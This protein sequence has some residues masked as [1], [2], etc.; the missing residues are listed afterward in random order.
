MN[1][2]M[3]RN[4]QGQRGQAMAVLAISAVALLALA[5]LVIDGGN[6]FA[7]QR[8]TQNGADAASE[9]GA[10][11]LMQKLAGVV[12]TKTGSDVDTAVQTTA[13]ANGLITPVQACYTDLDG[14]PLASDGSMAAD[15]SSAAQVGPGLP[16]PP[17]SA[18]PGSFAAGVE[19]H[20]SRSFTGYFGGIVGLPDGLASAKATARAGYVNGLSGPVVPLT[21]PVFASGCDGSNKLVTSTNSWPVG[22][23]NVLAIPLCQN[24]PG[25]VGWLDWTPTAG[26][27][28]ELAGA[29]G[30]S[31]PNPTITTPRW[32]YVTATGNVN[33]GQVQTA[34]DMW[35]GQQIRLPIFS[36]TCNNTPANLTNTIGQVSD[37]VTGG[38]TLGGNGSNQWYF[39]VGFAAFHL[40]QSFINGGDGGLCNANYPAGL[41]AGG[42]GGTSCLIGYFV[43]PTDAVSLGA[44]VGAGGGSDSGTSPVGVQ[45]I[46]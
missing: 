11:V 36:A 35:N 39:L 5:A 37:C 7:Q 21:F 13:A 26:G 29:I 1:M 32:Y 8:I 15:C 33:S 30:G 14:N 23:G 31:P 22:P 20:G 45:L 6:A 43:G 2:A 16:I 17:C 38:G 3:I 40:N 10:V 44:S 12:P 19:V 41:V 42:G 28:S 4:G 25:N 34:M 9:S 46:R 24:D 18:C 27:A